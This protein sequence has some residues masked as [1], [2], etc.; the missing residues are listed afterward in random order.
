MEALHE[1]A[2]AGRERARLRRTLDAFRNGW[3]VVSIEPVILAVN[4]TPDGIEAWLA[5]IARA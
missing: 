3:E 5:E 4:F 2:P 1:V